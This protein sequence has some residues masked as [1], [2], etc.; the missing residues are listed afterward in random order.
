MS[1][2]PRNPLSPAAVRS[3]LNVAARLR[4]QGDVQRARAVL[5]ALAAQ[6]PNDPRVWRALADV[7]ESEEER[8]AALRRVVALVRAAAA[9]KPETTPAGLSAASG[10]SDAHASGKAREQPPSAASLPAGQPVASPDAPASSPTPPALS[11]APPSTPAVPAGASSASADQ[12]SMPQPEQ[13]ALS[14]VGRYKWIGVAAIG[15]ALLIFALL[16]ANARFPGATTGTAPTLVLT[17]LEPVSGSASPAPALDPSASAPAVVPTAPTESLRESPVATIAPATAPSPTATVAPSPT[18]TPLP[19]LP[20]GTVILRD[21]WT[22]TLLRPDHAIV[23]NGPIG[24]KQ[25]TGR[26]VLALVAVG[27][28]GDKAIPAPPE[29]FVLID[30]QGNRYLP[31]PGLSTF[32]L[33]TFGRGRYGDFS[34]DEA[35]PAGVGQ[36][37]VP[38]IFDVPVDARGLTLHLGDTVAGWPVVGLP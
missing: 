1:D 26:F 21:V 33:E 19:T 22:L 8:R 30:E 13:T 3:L 6:L 35:I 15:A 31:E 10:A 23:L 7:A 24:S 29:L 34:L 25:P 2:T 9:A 11:P 28:S 36:V 38:V 32:Y 17:T 5:R 4:Q 27:N 16:F 14:S 37:S 20:A 12:T 18:L